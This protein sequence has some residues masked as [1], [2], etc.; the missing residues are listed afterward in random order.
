M[1]L[2]PHLSLR[3]LP[4]PLP[5]PRPI[6]TRVECHDADR[7]FN[8]NTFDDHNMLLRGPMVEISRRS[9]DECM[10][11]APRATPVTPFFSVFNSPYYV[12]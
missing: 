7:R 3:P 9:F 6:L 1:P 11:W 12:T 2:S 5:S 4:A 8:N 10:S